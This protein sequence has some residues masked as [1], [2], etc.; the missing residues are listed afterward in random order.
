MGTYDQMQVCINGHQITARAQRSPELRAKHCSQ[1][2]VATIDQCPSCQASIRGVYDVPGVFAARATPVPQYCHN[3]GSAYPWQEAAIENL[4]DVLREGDLSE[5]DFAE[6]ESAL[7]DVIRDTP[8]TESASLRVK[9]LLGG[10]GKPVYDV[11]VRVISD[12]ASETAKKT[13][14]L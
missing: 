5:A 14:G 8:K 12:I 13:M 3:C 6:L 4:R 9:R 11:A 1:C 10:V 2:G 7:P